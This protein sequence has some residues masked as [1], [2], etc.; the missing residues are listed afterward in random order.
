MEWRRERARARV[1]IT[2]EDNEEESDVEA[3]FS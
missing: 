2:M 3:T 1:I